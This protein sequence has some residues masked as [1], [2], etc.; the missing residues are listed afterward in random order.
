MGVSETLARV[1]PTLAWVC[2]TLAWVCPTLAWVCPTL[3]WVCLTLAALAGAGVAA[4]GE[5]AVV[6]AALCASRPRLSRIRKL[7]G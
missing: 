1:C 2:P 4:G 5:P 6:R 7:A 3:A